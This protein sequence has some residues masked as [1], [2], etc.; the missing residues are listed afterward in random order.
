MDRTE[1][2]G[3]VCALYRASGG[4][5]RVRRG[6]LT[7]PRPERRSGS[8][9]GA[10]FLQV[11]QTA[12]LGLRRWSAL[13]SDADEWLTDARNYDYSERER[14]ELERAGQE[15]LA[16][17]RDTAGTLRHLAEA[18]GSAEGGAH[19]AAF[20]AAVTE[21]IAGQIERAK[22]RFATMQRHRLEGMWRGDGRLRRGV[23]E[24]GAMQKA[25]V[26]P[27][28]LRRG[29]SVPDGRP[30]RMATGAAAASR[31]DALPVD[32][33]PGAS[34]PPYQQQQQMEQAS[35]ALWSLEDE[36]RERD[37]QTQRLEQGMVELSQLLQQFALE[38]AKQANTVE[39]VHD[40]AVRA[41][42]Y[43]QRGHRELERIQPSGQTFQWFVVVFLV[44]MALSL[45]LLDARR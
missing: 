4:E 10:R 33:A 19:E 43:V 23:R 38:I 14:D 39:S 28:G 25:P 12:G 27:L 21:C 44:V 16:G 32:E 22:R 17:L 30:E 2:F 1:E 20:R 26:A 29:V 41:H 40:E 3:K 5:K 35:S 11:A 36:W 9:G 13:L 7:L 37:A 24:G 31:S 34:S 8:E 18:A 6:W 15:L 45:L 42:T